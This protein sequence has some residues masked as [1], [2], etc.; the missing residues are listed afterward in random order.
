MFSL[1]VFRQAQSRPD[2]LG[3]NPISAPVTQLSLDRGWVV[4][5]PDTYSSPVNIQ[6]DS[7]RFQ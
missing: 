5:E 3:R 7:H 6:L 4:V 1:E 2:D